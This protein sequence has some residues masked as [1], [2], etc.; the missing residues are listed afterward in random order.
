MLLYNLYGHIR[1]AELEFHSFLFSALD[2][3][4]LFHILQQHGH[5]GDI[6]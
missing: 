1:G 4:H 5:G 2:S 6:L 3:E